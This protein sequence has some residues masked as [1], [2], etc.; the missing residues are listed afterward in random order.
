MTATLS[1]AARSQHRDDRAAVDKAFS[2]LLALGDEPGSLLGVSELGRRAELSKSTAFRLL[3]MLERNGAVE[4][5]GRDYRIG[6]AMQRLVRPVDEGRQERLR[7]LLIP[8]CV[9]L[10]DQTGEAVHLSVLD[11]VDVVALHRVFG[12]RSGRGPGRVGTRLPAY[13]SA[14]GKA[15]LAHDPA[16]L[17]LVLAGPLKPLTARTLTEP[18]DLTA[19]L[20]RIRGG[21]IAVSLGEAVFGITAIAAPVRGTDGLPRAALT[22][23]ANEQSADVCRHALVLRRTAADA[24]RILQGAERSGLLRSA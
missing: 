13:A 16:A 6:S 12:G 24:S 19:Q 18:E 2:L 10:Y 11:G 21:A 17:D 23:V 4:R 3:S 20:A 7:E 14:A 1:P 8:A 9:D 22:L 15:L 5:V